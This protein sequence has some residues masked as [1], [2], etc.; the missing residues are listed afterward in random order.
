MEFTCPV[1]TPEERKANRVWPGQWRNTL[2]FMTDYEIVPGS[3]KRHFHTGVDLNLPDN[4][5]AGAPVYAIADGVVVFS[6]HV[7]TYTGK[8]STW[9][10]LIVIKHHESLYSRYAHLEQRMVKKGDHVEVGQGIGVIGHTGGE[11]LGRNWEHLHFDICVSDIL[12]DDRRGP[13]Y[14]PGAD[15]RA[16]RQNFIDPVTFLRLHIQPDESVLW[17]ESTD[18]LNVR[19]EPGLNGSIIGKLKPGTRLDIYAQTIEKD[20][21]YWGLIANGP[22]AGNYVATRYVRVLK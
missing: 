2:P 13:M 15:G 10:N 9:G 18:T 8:D 3:K 12:A 6:A 20:G 14:W 22:Y 16:V 17:V 4:K 11:K 21:Y 5:D 19:K 1:G 7:P